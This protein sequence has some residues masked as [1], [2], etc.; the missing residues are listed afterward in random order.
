LLIAIILGS[1]NETVSHIEG[2]THTTES[3]LLIGSFI[4]AESQHRHL[5]SVIQFDILH[6]NDDENEN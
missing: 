2:I 3:Y 1:I 6:I 4:G 5:H